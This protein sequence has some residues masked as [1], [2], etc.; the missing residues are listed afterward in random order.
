[1]EEDLAAAAFGAASSSSSAA[2]AAAAASA[3]APPSPHAEVCVRDACEM[4]LRRVRDRDVVE[5]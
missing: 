1:V 5:M 2:A 3:L 4:W